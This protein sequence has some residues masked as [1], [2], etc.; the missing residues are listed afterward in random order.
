MKR[1]ILALA[2]LAGVG[3]G[4]GGSGSGS[5]EIPPAYAE[6]KVGQDIPFPNL[7]AKDAKGRKFD[8][9][10][11]AQAVV[12]SELKVGSGAK[13]PNCIGDHAQVQD[14]GNAHYSI[15][16]WVEIAGVRRTY[17]G[18]AL[19]L[20]NEDGSPHATRITRLEIEKESK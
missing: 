16:S 4:S 17:S 6:Y 18:D 8:I 3:C 14:I 1:L 20:E 7:I 19:I 15:D 13:F 11:N 10:E 12:R 9:C 2:A 5:A